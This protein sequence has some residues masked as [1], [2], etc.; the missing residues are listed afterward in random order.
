[1][2]VTIV[3]NFFNHH[4]LPVANAFY[5]RLGE[6]FHFITTEKLPEERAALGYHD[7]NEKYSY[8]LCA[9][10]SDKQWKECE[11]I[12]FESDVT[13]FGY[14]SAPIK[15]IQR[16]IA[17]NKLV[18]FYMERIFKKK[19][20][21]K[22]GLRRKVALLWNHGRYQ[23]KKVFILAASAFTSFDFSKLHLYKN[24]IYKWGYFPEIE[25]NVK[26]SNVNNQTQIIWVGR[27]IDWK[28]P[29]QAI[30]AI[31]QL[32]D[33]GYSNIHL[34]MIGTGEML[35]QMKQM[36]VNE[37]LTTCIT[38]CG[39]MSPERVRDYMK[40]S[41]ILLFTSDRNEGW[42]AVLN[43]AMNSGCVPIANRMIG[44][45]PYMVQDN[46][47]GMIYAENE[48]TVIEIASRVKYLI[49]FE[50][51]R[52]KMATNAIK[53]TTEKWNAEFA[54]DRF[55]KMTEAMIA[56]KQFINYTDGPLSVAEVV[57]D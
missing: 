25:Y 9:Y 2:K 40:K 18:F 7:M 48:N 53:T 32:L 38:F 33:M 28:H 21:E 46:K 36:A 42:G 24:K 57:N 50:S 30:L 3:S 5:E 55:Q 39:S 34:N 56:E 6:D 52:K 8:V 54:V 23:N 14:S 16:R 37:K 41:D 10:K 19:S 17:Q 4:Q 31:K 29:E 35:N 13:I 15:L 22:S 20:F 45:V 49:D 27:F 1:M 47:N 43:E 11:K 12:I 44:S 26:K 51:E